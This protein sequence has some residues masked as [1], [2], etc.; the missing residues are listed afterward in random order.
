M[1]STR[2]FSAKSMRFAAAVSG[3]LLTLTGCVSPSPILD[4][5]FGKS[6]SLIKAQ[7]TLNPSA[8]R[9]TNPVSGLDGVAAKSAYDAYQKSFRTPEPVS[10]AFSIG[11][12][13]GR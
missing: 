11:I 10:N 1:A 4:A 2:F 9:N 6:V 3:L 8:S 13:G 7:Q 12:G 5:Q